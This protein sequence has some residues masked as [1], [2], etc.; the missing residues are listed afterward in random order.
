MYESPKLKKHASMVMRTVGQAVAG[1]ST[2]DA[3]V[4]VLRTLGGAHSKYGVQPAHF[5]VVGEALL[6]TLEQGLGGLWTADVRDAWTRTFALVRSVMEPAL[7]E[8]NQQRA[9]AA[10]NLDSDL[11]RWGWGGC[12]FGEMCV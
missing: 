4:P 8:A 9:A 2:P 7:V 5:D 10:T 6:W 12:C 11:V 3:L 1:L